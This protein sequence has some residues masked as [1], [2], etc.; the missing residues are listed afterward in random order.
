[1]PSMAPVPRPYF[2]RPLI[3]RRVTSPTTCR[4]AGDMPRV[5]RPGATVCA[6]VF[7][8]DEVMMSVRTSLSSVDNPFCSAA[9]QEAYSS[10]GRI[11][12]ATPTRLPTKAPTPAPPGPK[13]APIF[14]PA[15]APPTPAPIL[16]AKDGA[17]C[18]MA[19]PALPMKPC[20]AAIRADLASCD[21]EVPMYSSAKPATDPPKPSAPRSCSPRPTPPTSDSPTCCAPTPTLAKK[22]RGWEN[23]AM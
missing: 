1:M 4:S 9:S 15:A 22:P 8:I 5:I 14:A 11:D 13:R 7:N 17:L 3:V 18:A 16:A 6:A 20:S 21:A 2:M 23:D 10:I 19:V 12:A